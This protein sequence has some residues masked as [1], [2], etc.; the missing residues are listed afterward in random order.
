[1]A[2]VKRNEFWEFREKLSRILMRFAL[3][4]HVRSSRVHSRLVQIRIRRGSF[5]FLSRERFD[6]SSLIY[7][8]L[9]PSRLLNWIFFLLCFFRSSKSGIFN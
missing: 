1:M 2:K 3:D 5:L 9:E 7:L 6:A 8:P 4:L